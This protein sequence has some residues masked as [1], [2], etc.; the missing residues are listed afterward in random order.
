MAGPFPSPFC[1][2][3]RKKKATCQTTPNPFPS[4]SWWTSSPRSPSFSF[5]PFPSL[6]EN[7]A[8]R[9]VRRRGRAFPFF[10]F[11]P[12]PHRPFFFSLFPPVTCPKRKES[13]DKFSFSSFS[14]F[15]LLASEVTRVA[16]RGGTPKGLFCPPPFFSFSLILAAHRPLLLFVANGDRYKK[17]PSSPVLFSPRCPKTP[18]NPFFLLL[19]TRR[20]T[21][22]WPPHCPFPFNPHRVLLIS[23]PPFP[24]PVPIRGQKER[25]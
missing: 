8:E 23:S 25:K 10:F 21:E 13:K 5:F 3:D 17:S 24:S 2:D 1:S 7:W 9:N 18:S 6:K 14:P 20:G 4:Q 19:V 11:W 22:K 16:R 12:A 15:P